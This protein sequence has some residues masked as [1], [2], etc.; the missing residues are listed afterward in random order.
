[1]CVEEFVKEC[2]KGCV[3]ERR[4]L[5]GLTGKPEDARGVPA[6]FGR[7]LVWFYRRAYSPRGRTYTT[8]DCP[9]SAYPTESEA[10]R[11]ESRNGPAAAHRDYPAACG[12]GARVAVNVKSNVKSSHD[13]QS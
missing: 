6:V 12:S 1:M 3:K 2:V 5:G 9:L 7:F 8:H 4:R 11:R 13:S 10:G